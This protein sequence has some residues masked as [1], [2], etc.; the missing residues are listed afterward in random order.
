MKRLLSLAVATIFV[1]SGSVFAAETATQPAKAATEQ[2]SAT[3]H[4]AGEQTKQ[5]KKH[6]KAKKEVKDAASQ[7]AAK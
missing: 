5:H 2:S 3:P 7:P 4:K 1:L 6:S